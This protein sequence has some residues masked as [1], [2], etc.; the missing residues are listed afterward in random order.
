MGTGNK[1]ASAGNCMCHGPDIINLMETLQEI[2][3]VPLAEAE[4]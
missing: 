1:S 4:G 2:K 3:V